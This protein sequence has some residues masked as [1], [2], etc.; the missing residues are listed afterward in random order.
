MNAAIE[1]QWNVGM[2][3]WDWIK[4]FEKEYRKKEAKPEI[5]RAS[6]EKDRKPYPPSIQKMLAEATNRMTL[7]PKEKPDADHDHRKPDAAKP[8]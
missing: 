1:C 7:H 6:D 3:V 8:S 2:K 4:I 5:F